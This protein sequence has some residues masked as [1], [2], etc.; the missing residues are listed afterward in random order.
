MVKLIAIDMDGTLLNKGKYI[1][2]NNLA[3][4]RMAQKNGTEIVVATGRANFDAHSFFEEIDINP[5]IIG[6]N[7]ATIH[8]P[9]G[10]LFHSVPLQKEMAID[11]LRTLEEESIYYEAFID[12]KIS[13]PAYGKKA[14]LQDIEDTKQLGQDIDH[15]YLEMDIQQG[16]KGYTVIPSFE[17]L[18]DSSIDIYNILAVSFKE[19]KLLNGWAKFADIPNITIV[20]SGLYNFHLQNDEASKGNALRIL[21]KQLNIDL[22]DTAAVGDN[23]NDLSMLTIA[24]K[25]AAMANADDAIKEQCDMV[26]KANEE[27][28]VAHFIHTIMKESQFNSNVKS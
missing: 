9:D 21:A 24:G 28:G 17:Q 27:D 26:T 7:G 1:S 12:N 6:T 10:Q 11:M 25:S 22:A 16:Q 14:L 18:L 13:T 8:R 4:L 3:A 19:E 23:Y 2:N 5:W 15:M 20:K